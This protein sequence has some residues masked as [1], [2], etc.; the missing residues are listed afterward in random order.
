M[1]KNEK[2]KGREVF[3]LGGNLRHRSVTS[4]TRFVQDSLKPNK[5]SKT[6]RTLDAFRERPKAI[7]RLTG[8]PN[9]IQ[10]QYRRKA[11]EKE[12]QATTKG[13]TTTIIAKKVDS[14]HL[15]PLQFHFNE[16]F[17][18]TTPASVTKARR[19]KNA[20]R[21]SLRQIVQCN[22]TRKLVRAAL[23]TTRDKGLLRLLTP[24]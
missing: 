13:Q 3:R 8:K 4:Y 16:A 9:G 15:S 21:R 19:T 22:R 12:R 1:M 18:Q 14:S 23:M 10:K 7:E 17:V 6:S 24:P 5:T 2:T 11:S 20:T